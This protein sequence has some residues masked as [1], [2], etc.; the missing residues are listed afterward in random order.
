MSRGALYVFGYGS[1][2][3]SPELPEAVL[4][5]LPAR[6]SGHRRSFNKISR[7]SQCRVEESFAAFGDP[8]GRFR[9]GA[10]YRSL[11][12]GTEPSAGAGIDGFLLAYPQEVRDSGGALGRFAR[13]ADPDGHEWGLWEGAGS[14]L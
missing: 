9:R 8:L 5:V 4:E 6:L 7:R 12:L 2:P 10:W 13:F 14:G 1:L 11:V 3:F